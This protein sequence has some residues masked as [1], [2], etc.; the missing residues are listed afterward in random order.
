[1]AVGSCNRLPG[2]P[3]RFLGDVGKRKDRNK[4]FGK[5]PEDLKFFFFFWGGGSRTMRCSFFF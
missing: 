5:R 2:A 1:M 3:V 4:C